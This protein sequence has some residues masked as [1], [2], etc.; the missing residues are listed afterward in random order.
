MS[1][2]PMQKFMDWLQY[3]VT[4]AV[5]KFTERPWVHGFSAGIVKL[6]LIHI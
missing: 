2:K 1:K 6:S 5:Q 4:P 3:K